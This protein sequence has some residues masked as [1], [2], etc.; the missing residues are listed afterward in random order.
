MLF[1]IYRLLLLL[2]IIGISRSSIQIAY[3]S[4]L[5]W[6]MLHNR[7]IEY[8]IYFVFVYYALKNSEVVYCMDPSTEMSLTLQ[9]KITQLEN[10]IKYY[11]EQAMAADRDFKEVLNT[12]TYYE[13][14]GAML[15]WQREYDIAESALKDTNTNLNSE[16]RMRNILK[17][18]L[19]SGDYDMTSKSTAAK[20][21][22]SD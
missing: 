17:A 15:E 7:K 21:K 8:V 12:K 10:K 3:S 13:A 11:Q 16:I 22:S 19:E 14:K 18:K 1:A 9:D 20:R 4:I 5:C 6:V 2:Y